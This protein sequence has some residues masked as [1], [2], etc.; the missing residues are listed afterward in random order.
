MTDIEW[1]PAPILTFQNKLVECVC[2]HLEHAGSGPTC[3]CGL[4]PGVAVS[5]EGCGECGN[6]AC[7]MGY[8]RPGR[9]F[10]YATFPSAVLDASCV[11]PIAYQFEVGVL[12]CFPTMN[13]QGE[14]P[15][16]EEIT[17]VTNKVTQDAWALHRAIRCCKDDDFRGTVTI[18]EWT[19]I[20]PAGGCVGGFWTIYVDPFL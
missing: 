12:R 11:K 16:A 4:Y 8:V 1:R 18:Q 2:T 9:V 3:W 7:G 15:P 6:G 14:F 5:W 10:P 17:E 20:G 19:P 13:D